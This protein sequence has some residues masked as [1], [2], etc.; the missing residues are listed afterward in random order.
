MSLNKR[1]YRIGAIPALTACLAAPALFANSG[2]ETLEEVQSTLCCSDF[3]VGANL[4]GVDFEAGVNFHAWIQA[5]ADFS[6][7][8]S[9][10][11]TD[12]G[13]ACMNL[14][15][16]LGAS[17]TAVTE[18]DPA[19]RMEQWCAKA[20]AQIDASLTA[21]G[22]I[23]I[24]IDFQPPACNFSVS[25]QASC[26]GGCQV[27]ASCE[28]KL[29]DISLRCSPGELSGKCS[30]TC[31]AKCEGSANLAVTCGGTCDGTCEGTCDGNQSSGS[32]SGKCEG[33]CRGSCDMTGEAAVS[34]E[35]ECT[36]GCSVDVTAPKC[37]GEL[38]SP[39]EIGCDI[40]ADCSA[41]CKASASAKAECKPPSVDITVNGTVTAEVE[42]IVASL[43]LFLPE[44]VGIIKFR[45]NMLKVN[46]EA[47][48][49]ATVA[50]NPGELSG[51]A[52]LCIIPAL[53][54]I[55]EMFTN[56]SASVTVSVSMASSLNLG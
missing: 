42:L 3:D 56:L 18:T 50:L 12:L 5:V 49:N 47:L 25:A 17:E 2:C 43:K 9:A 54:V 51:K 14:A 36:G 13:S 55:Q 8:A 27:D 22:N 28:A 10:M 52:A 30:G 29:P 7:T 19:K 45:A 53:S 41:S 21:A 40:N 32:C 23:T 16:D 15:V 37:K 24:G 48:V 34:C 4:S 33:K 39:G 31:S 26:E 6:G 46:A 44:I 11:V 1:I 20:V 38:K 35:G